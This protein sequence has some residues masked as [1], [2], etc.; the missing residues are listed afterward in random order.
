MNG[1]SARRSVILLCVLVLGLARAA[2]GATYTV[3]NSANSGAGTLRTAITNANANPGTD[4]IQFSLP[5]G[6]LTIPVSTELP[7]VVERAKILGTTQ[8]GYSNAP[9]VTLNA[10]SSAVTNGLFLGAIGCT[11]TAVRVHGFTSGIMVTS[12]SCV[13]QSCYFMSNTDAGVYIRAG[14]SQILGNYFASNGIGVR[15][16]TGTTNSVLGNFIG[17][18]PLTGAVNGNRKG[19]FIASDKNFIGGTGTNDGNVIS[20]NI[21][22]GIEISWVSS[23]NTIRGNLIGTDAA[24]TGAVPND[25]GI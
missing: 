22:R 11:V 21:L 9:L 13:I 3:T 19:V 25:V 16:D 18:H 1:K 15:L 14:G 4:T 20:G 17:V 7:R 5:A 12:P 10:A 24:G 6:S 8:P 23:S 2:G